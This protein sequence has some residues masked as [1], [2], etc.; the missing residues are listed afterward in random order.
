MKIINQIL[1]VLLFVS[2]VIISGIHGSLFIS[3]LSLLLL[4]ILLATTIPLSRFIFGDWPDAYVFAFPIGFIFHAILLSFM[5]SIFGIRAGLFVAYILAVILAAILFFV[6]QRQAPNQVDSQKPNAESTDGSWNLPDSLWLWIWLLVLVLIVSVPLLK[7]GVEIPQGFAYRAYFDADFFRNLAVIG[8][9]N[10]HG[11]PPDNPYVSGFILYYYWFFHIFIAFWKTI[12]PSYRSDF[13]LIQ[14]TL[15]SICMFASSVFVLLRSVTVSRKTL[16]LCLFLLAFGG[17]YKAIHI[18]DYVSDKHMHWQSFTGFNVEGI[19]RWHW[20]APQIDTFFR[21]FLYAP[22]HLIALSI[23]FPILLVWSKGSSS[24]TGRIILYVALFSTLG[25]SAFI[26]AVLIL[27]AGIILV[28]QSIRNPRQKQKELFLAA[29]IGLA[30]LFLYLYYFKIIQVGSGSAGLSVSPDGHILS[31]FFSY[32]ILN[33]GAFLIFGLLGILWFPK[34]SPFG[35]LLFLLILCWFMIVFLRLNLPGFSDISLKVG[36]ITHVILLIFAASFLDR[37]FSKSSSRGTLLTIAFFF[38][39]L[40]G[41]AT[42]MMDAFNSQDI[43]NRRFTTLISSGDAEVF[44][45]MRQNVPPQSVVQTV[46]AKGGFLQEFVT[47]VPAFA[48]RSVFLGDRNFS[49]IFQ[50]SKS[51]VDQRTRIVQRLFN[52]D[53]PEEMNQDCRALGIDFV[54]QGNKQASV[55][56]R[57]LIVEPFFTIVKRSGDAVLF[58]V[59]GEKAASAQR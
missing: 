29:G 52:Q 59:N 22:Q 16:F 54:F 44:D 58:H 20:G 3:F 2:I 1:A 24:L 15:V 25:F 7:V 40:P 27:S 51:V 34:R 11:I 36:Y 17:S 23:L 46:P 57:Q 53:N 50:I 39:L 8:S 42:W 28:Y 41:L 6:K 49:R 9:L 10:S 35:I 26:G 43:Q 4:L 12:F 48:E 19:L 32:F 55:Q 21:A 13:M 33:W 37:I 38:I 30:F 47:E 5:G 56:T 31:H 14:F 18:F 45:W